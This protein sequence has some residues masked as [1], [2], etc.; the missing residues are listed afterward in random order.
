MFLL[1]LDNPSAAA[2]IILHRLETVRMP[3][4]YEIFVDKQD[5]IRALNNL[6]SWMKFSFFIRN[7]DNWILKV[8]NDL[9]V[10]DSFVVILTLSVFARKF[11]FHKKFQF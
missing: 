3:K 10:C 4:F 5:M 1:I 7:L 2:G 6:F 9:Q 8:M 11:H